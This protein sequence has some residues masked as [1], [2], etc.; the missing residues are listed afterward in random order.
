MNVPT[1]GKR[2]SECRTCFAGMIGIASKQ[3]TTNT[4][5]TYEIHCRT[6]SLTSRKAASAVGR[7]TSQRM[8]KTASSTAA[9]R[10]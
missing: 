6:L 3:N 5:T 2:L 1:F 8:P 10:P 4:S 7:E 9:C